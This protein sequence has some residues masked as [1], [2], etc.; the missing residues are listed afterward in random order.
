MATAAVMDVVGLAAVSSKGVQM[1]GCS[2]G[3]LLRATCLRLDV[4]L[5]LYLRR[6]RHAGCD[7]HSHCAARRACPHTWGREGSGVGEGEWRNGSRRARQR[8]Y[9]HRASTRHH[10]STPE[11]AEHDQQRRHHQAAPGVRTRLCVAW[12]LEAA[13]EQAVGTSATYSAGRQRARHHQQE[14]VRPWPLH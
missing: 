11:E 10:A 8:A 12:R 6:R 4:L 5:L 7:Q 2:G 1:Q 3:P 14:S 9:A 13:V